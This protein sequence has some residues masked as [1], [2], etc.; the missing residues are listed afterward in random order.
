MRRILSVLVVTA[1]AAG[2]AAGARNPNRH[3]QGEMSRPQT[4]IL[5]VI[6]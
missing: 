4:G 2:P 6:F 3:H 1:L 5:F